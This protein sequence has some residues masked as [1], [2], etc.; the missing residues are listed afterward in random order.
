VSPD[1]I[2]RV[3]RNAAGVTAD[4]VAQG[5][6]EEGLGPLGWLPRIGDGRKRQDHDH[7]RQGRKRA[8]EYT[9]N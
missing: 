3:F 1:E 5:R 4:D 2:D 7:A 6:D 9:A 8:I